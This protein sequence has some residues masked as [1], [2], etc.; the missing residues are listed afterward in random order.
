MAAFATSYIPTLASS[1]TR[2]ADVASVDTLSPFYNQTEGTFL[3][4]FNQV[5]TN[6]VASIG[7]DTFNNSLRFN[8]LN[9]ARGTGTGFPN[10]VVL[11]TSQNGS[12]KLAVAMKVNDYAGSFN[13]AAVS[14]DTTATM[15]PTP[16]VLG[17]G[18]DYG[19]TGYMSG[20][21][22]RVA[23]YPRRLTD[24]ELVALSA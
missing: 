18:R 22:R 15:V 6:P 10:Q 20:H 12:R 24:A 11:G 1:V 7:D 19:T 13:G 3:F 5:D 2:S 14:T 9:M 8:I 23:Y 17:L 4:D 16:S 21:L